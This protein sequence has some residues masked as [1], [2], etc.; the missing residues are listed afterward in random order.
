MADN[1][2]EAVLV[3][4][5]VGL[6][7]ILIGYRIGH[8]L[9]GCTPDHDLFVVEQYKLTETEGRIYG[10]ANLPMLEYR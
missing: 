5:S 10:S 6:N 3:L 7:G 9:P 8:S 2:V 4:D 1:L